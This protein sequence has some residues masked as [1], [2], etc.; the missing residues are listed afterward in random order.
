MKPLKFC[1]VHSGLSA[2]LVDKSNYDGIWVSSLTHSASKGLPDNELVSLME[3]VELVSEISRI[4]NKP[5]LVDVDTMGDIRHTSQYSKWF[6]KSGAWG[7]VIEDKKFP[8]EN[9]LLSDGKH[10]L[11]DIDEFC[12]K[13][14][15]AKKNISSLKIIA[16][17]ES[18]IAGHSI[19]DAITRAKAYIDAGADGILIHSKE[20]ITC[21]G[22]MQVAKEIRGFNKDIL[23]IAIPTTYILPEEH[24]FGITINANQMLRASLKGMQDYL[25]GGDNISSVEDIFNITGK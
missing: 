21:E 1:E 23:L 5:I 17:L 16:R 8:K 14:K 13:I 10:K 9:S 6:E 2:L 15:E 4:S 22:V 7:I 19:F 3:R 12:Q 25:N 24:E 18:L 11:E 20:K